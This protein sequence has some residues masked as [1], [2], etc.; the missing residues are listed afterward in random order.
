MDRLRSLI[1]SLGRIKLNIKNGVNLGGELFVET[2][3]AWGD[4]VGM[5]STSLLFAKIMDLLNMQIKGIY[6][7]LALAGLEPRGGR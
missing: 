6:A 2:H 3:A 7:L 4:F 5:L 1:R